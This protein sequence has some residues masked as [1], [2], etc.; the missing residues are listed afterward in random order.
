[1]RSFIHPRGLP[2]LTWAER[3]KATWGNLM[4]DFTF[5]CV[6]QQKRHPHHMAFFENPEDLGA[7]QQGHLLG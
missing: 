2:R 5:A 6:G 1:M 3:R 4:A 7:I